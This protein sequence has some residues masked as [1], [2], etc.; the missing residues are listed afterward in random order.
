MQ[1]AFHTLSASAVSYTIPDATTWTGL[2]IIYE[3]QGKEEKPLWSSIKGQT[4]GAG[5]TIEEQSER[6]KPRNCETNNALEGLS[7][8][9]SEQMNSLSEP[10]RIED[11]CFKQIF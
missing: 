11:L 3:E 5:E 8:E 1:N 10:V 2:T 4:S 6:N 7:L 9:E